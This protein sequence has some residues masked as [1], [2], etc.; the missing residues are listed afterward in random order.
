MTGG[1]PIG[2]SGPCSHINH[3]A[4]ITHVAG[5]FEGGG[6]LPAWKL[7]APS[8][9]TTHH[10]PV[11]VLPYFPDF[12]V[13]PGGGLGISDQPEADRPFRFTHAGGDIA[14]SLS[15]AALSCR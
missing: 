5:G 11:C 4:R 1:G 7:S 15:V 8:S 10:Q 14:F 13:A 3:S 9:K 6:R 2:P 12:S